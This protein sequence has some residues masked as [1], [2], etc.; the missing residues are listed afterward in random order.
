MGI[1]RSHRGRRPH[2]RLQPALGFPTAGGTETSRRG[3]GAQRRRREGVGRRRENRHRG[4][5]HK[6][7]A[8]L[9]LG[10]ARAEAS[11]RIVSLN[12]QARK[13]ADE[14]A[15]ADAGKTG[16]VAAY[17]AYIQNFG[18]GAHVAQAR[19][20]VTEQ[21]RKEADEKAWADAVL[22]RTV[23]AFTAYT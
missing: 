18:G 22:A 8:E 9:R 10:R 3:A 14:K 13:D 6:L 21:T 5:I 12:D 23:A 19:Q 20:R 16:T 1:C 17:M 7:F 2:F 11:Q 15:W 4:G